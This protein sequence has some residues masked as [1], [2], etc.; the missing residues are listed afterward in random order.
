MKALSVA[1]AVAIIA[2]L[3]LTAFATDDNN[4]TSSRWQAEVQNQPISAAASVQDEFTTDQITLSLQFSSVHQT[5]DG[6]ITTLRRR[7]S[8]VVRETQEVGMNV[9]EAVITHMELRRRRS[10]SDDFRYFGNVTVLLTVTGSTD[11][12]EVA[13]RLKRLSARSVGELRYSLSKPALEVAEQKLRSQALEKIRREAASEAQLRNTEL[14]DMHRFEFETHVNRGS[15]R[16]GNVVVISGR[17]LA[18]F[19]PHGQ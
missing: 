1:A 14:G 6:L 11:P 7:K 18:V 8:A 3:P 10:N 15:P 16:A 13:S 17:G 19:K 9:A 4:T 2:G 5:F 12:L